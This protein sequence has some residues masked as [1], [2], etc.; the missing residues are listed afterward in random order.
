MSFKDVRDSIAAALA[1]PGIW[2]VHTYPV[3][4]P[5]PKSI[6]ITPAADWVSPLTTGRKS[7]ELRFSLKLTANT[8][9]NQADLITLEDMIEDV[10]GL[11]PSWLLFEGVSAPTELQVGTAY[12]TTCDMT[13]RVAATL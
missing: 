3:P 7:V 10:I 11:L 9:D 2:E 6:I 4:T 1:N 5:M 12:L 13:V 8:A